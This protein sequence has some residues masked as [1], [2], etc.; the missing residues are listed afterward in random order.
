MSLDSIA[1]SYF[2]CAE[3]PVWI[4]NDYDINRI[5]DCGSCKLRLVSPVAGPGTLSPRKDGLLVDENPLATLSVNG[6]Q[7]NL[8]ET[9]LMIG[10]AH[11]LSKRSD[12]CKA[13]LACYFQNTRDF[14]QHVCL[15]LP[16]DIGNS[17]AGIK[18][19][20]TLGIVGASRPVFSTIVPPNATYLLY[21]GADFRGRSAKSTNPSKFCDPVARTTAYYVCTTPIFMASVDYT[22]LVSRAGKVLEGPPKPLT[23]VV[24]SRL[25]SLATRVK[26][27]II[28]AAAPL[29]PGGTAVEGPGYPTKAMKCYRLNPGRDIVKDRV[30]VGGI[31]SD[32]RKELE[33]VAPS[34]GPLPS[35]MPGDVQHWL[36]SSLGIIIA[37]I[38]ASFLFVLIF[39][40][41]FR[42]YE[43][44]QHLYSSPVSAYSIT[45]KIWP[46]G[47]KFFPSGWFSWKSCPEIPTPK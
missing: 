39:S 1:A 10:G 32:L 4:P 6:V 25:E 33:G 24:I 40:F 28:G 21:N 42:N 11:R 7:H 15:C 22:R 36:S 34:D 46:S 26:G 17:G 12:P 38:L 18:Y 41:V 43:A 37:I 44:A 29:G 35:V 23:P 13:E 16:I 31:S 3:S 45:N 14:S 8:I 47:I 2:G 27:I 20:S 30:Y 9:I 19:F 5:P